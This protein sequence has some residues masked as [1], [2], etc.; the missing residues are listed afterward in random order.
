MSEL[1]KIENSGPQLIWE[2]TMR[3]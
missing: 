1:M 2:F 3:A